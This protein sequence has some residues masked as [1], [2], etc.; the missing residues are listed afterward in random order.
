MSAKA[1]A[2]LFF[3]IGLLSSIG[4]AVLAQSAPPGPPHIFAGR[5][6]INRALAADGV[7]VSAVSNSG[8]LLGTAATHNGRYV[9]QVSRPSAGDTITFTAGGRAA[10]ESAVWAMGGTTILDLT[11]NSASAPLPSGLD[12]LGDNLVRLFHWDARNGGWS[13]YD[14]LIN[15]GQRLQHDLAPGRFYWIR[16]QR[17]Q[18]LLQEGRQIQLVAGWNKVVWQATGP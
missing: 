3:I 13:Y 5:A 12:Q 11:I 1:A 18:V 10:A 17:D 14:P 8:E 4:G 7:I 2:A 15:P 9:L 6:T 16:V